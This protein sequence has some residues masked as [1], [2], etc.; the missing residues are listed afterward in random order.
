MKINIKNLAAYIFI[1]IVSVLFML[2]LDG[3]GGTYLIIV[4]SAALIISFGIFLWTKAKLSYSLKLSEDVLNKG[5]ILNVELVL[6]KKGFLPTSMIKF[7]FSDCPLLYSETNEINSIVIFGH[8][9]EIVEKSFR[10]T[11]FGS[12]RTGVEKVVVSDYLGIFCYEI[13][14]R[15]LMQSVRI[16]PDIPDVSGKDSFAR[17]LAD[18][19]AFDDSEETT[20]SAD[21]I[22]GTPGYE[23]R[24]YFPGDNLK[25]INW[26]LSAKRG[27][28]LVRKLEGTGNAEQVFALAFDNFYFAESQ[29]AAEAMLGLI[30]NFA[31]AE[32]PVRVIVFIDDRWLE[33]PINN[34]GDLQQFRYDMTAYNIF[35]LKA[36]L[37]A[38]ERDA[39]RKRKIPE[40]PADER[41]VIFAPVCDAKLSAFM[42][43]LSSEGADCQLAVCGGETTDGRVRR[44][45][46]ESGNVRF[47]E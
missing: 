34:L 29:L 38:A 32:L 14:D 47:S 22:C 44:I 24:Q 30:M 1:M 40:V 39:L 4:T 9:E 45:F 28:L 21:S 16:Y 7:V 41:A 36:G 46:F 19:V 12:G 33:M 23:H 20:R 18:A 6:G 17:S 11:F 27:E 2:F 37:T 31:K 13:I 3:P 35:P 42:N 26:K 8:D 25:L 15:N 5:D 43:R 10:A